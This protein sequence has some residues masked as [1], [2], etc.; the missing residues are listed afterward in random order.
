MVGPAL[1]L[2]VRAEFLRTPVFQARLREYSGRRRSL[3]AW[4]ARNLPFGRP[5]VPRSRKNAR[6]VYEDAG[7]DVR[8][9]S[10][11]FTKWEARPCRRPTGSIDS[12]LLSGTFPK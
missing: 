12:Q 6:R 11:A 8:R 5:T 2:P 4:R 3:L 10:D 7:R 9:I 1:R